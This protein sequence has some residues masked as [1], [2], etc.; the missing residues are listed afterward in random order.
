MD[1]NGEPL[2]R[3]AR[4]NGSGDRQV[5]EADDDGQL[6]D[7]GNECDWYYFKGT[8]DGPGAMVRGQELTIN[9]SKYAFDWDGMLYLG[10]W[11]TVDDD[12]NI[13]EETVGPRASMAYYQMDGTRAMD[14][15]LALGIPGDASDADYWY[16]FNEDGIV[17]NIVQ[18]ASPKPTPCWRLR[19]LWWQ[20][21]ATARRRRPGAWKPC[22]CRTMFLPK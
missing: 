6:Y 12:G 13:I 19:M 2:L 1:E 17:T 7:G 21:Q 10:T 5:D 4:P 11:L 8:S 16:N 3:Y 15:K 14:K 22:M 9:G 20:A 18:V